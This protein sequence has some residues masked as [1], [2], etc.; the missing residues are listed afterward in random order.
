MKIDLRSI[1]QSLGYLNILRR[2]HIHRAAAENNIYVGQLP[3]LEYV[4][5]HGGCTQ[6]ELAQQ[7]Q[8]SAPSIATSVK[9]MQKTGLL[10]KTADVDDLRCTRITITEKGKKLAEKSRLSFDEIEARMFVGFTEEECRQLS[11][12]LSRM[13]SN[14][15]T[16][17][18]KGRSM[19]SLIVTMTNE[20]KQRPEKEGEGNLCS[21]N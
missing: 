7:L 10:E 17:E 20:K 21:D 5:Q 16:D 3:I 9:R 18:F 6:R 13:I 1:V 15:L 8:V 14:I 4:Q 12:Y 2:I 19:Y 11:G